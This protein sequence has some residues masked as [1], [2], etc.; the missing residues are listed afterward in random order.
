MMA[1][2]LQIGDAV[3]ISIRV[4]LNCTSLKPSPPRI[5]EPSG[6]EHNYTMKA[7]KSIYPA[8]KA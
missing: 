2:S 4:D 7:A 8:E 1:L 3:K 6:V 5:R